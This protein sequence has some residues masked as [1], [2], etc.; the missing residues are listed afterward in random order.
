MI[1]ENAVKA[2][3]NTTVHAIGG[4]PRPNL[5]GKLSTACQ[6]V[7]IGSSIAAKGLQRYPAIARTAEVIGRVA[8]TGACVLGCAAIAGYVGDIKNALDQRT[9]YESGL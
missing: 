4:E 8:W 5:A 9:E 3:C 1:T 7:V 2:A 6:S